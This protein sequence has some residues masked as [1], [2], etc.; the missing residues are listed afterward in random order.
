MSGCCTAR[1]QLCTL[2]WSTGLNNAN[3]GLSWHSL[4]QSLDLFYS[5]FSLQRQLPIPAVKIFIRFLPQ[6]SNKG[7]V[8]LGCWGQCSAVRGSQSIHTSFFPT[9]F[10][11]YTLITILVSS[12][13]MSSRSPVV[14]RTG[15]IH[16]WFQIRA[17]STGIS[18]MH[19]KINIIPAVKVIW[20]LVYVSF[21]EL[22]ASNFEHILLVS[23]LFST[24]IFKEDITQLTKTALETRFQKPIASFT[25]HFNTMHCH[26]LFF[27][28]IC[29]EIRYQVHKYEEG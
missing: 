25:S 12:L 14:S 13:P 24:K 23:H 6:G 5:L 20:F 8:L 4:T 19:T 17:K 15:D 21:Y 1:G 7:P 3:K 16:L 26:L 11:S 29:Y 27:Q 18:T 22:T 10:S 28:I 9:K 2:N